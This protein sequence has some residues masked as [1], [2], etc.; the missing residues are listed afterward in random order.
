MAVVWC[1]HGIEGALER[2]E[3]EAA[4]R[5]AAALEKFTRAEPLPR[6]DFFIARGRALV[7]HGRG[8]CDNATMEEL[9]LL[10]GEAEQIGLKLALPALEEALAAA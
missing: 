7:A 8:G 6:S 3:W 4:D 2:E 5:Y 9:K 1:C 10:R